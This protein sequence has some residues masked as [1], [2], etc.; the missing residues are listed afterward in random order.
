MLDE[1]GTEDEAAG[2]AVDEATELDGTELEETTELEATELDEA[3]ELLDEVLS[4]SPN[5]GLQPSPQ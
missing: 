1:A 5:K 4:Q 2:V 3:T